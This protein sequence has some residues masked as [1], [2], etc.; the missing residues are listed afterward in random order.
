MFFEV[1]KS[2]AVTSLAG[3]VLAGLITLAKPF[4]RK[5]FGYAWHYYIWLAV[6]LV[7][8]LP[9]RF[10]VWQG[11]AC[12]APVLY[13]QGPE[14]SQTAVAMP[15]PSASPVRQNAV[16]A[17]LERMKQAVGNEAQVYLLFLW[18]V[19]AVGFFL[20]YL[21]GYFL[22]LR[23]IHRHSVQIQCPTLRQYTDKNVRV[24]LC[25]ESSMP[26]MTGVFRPV[27]ILPN[28]PL[29]PVQMDHILRHEMTHF[30]RRDLLY[31]WFAVLV[32]CIH[33]FN[34]VVYYVMRQ[35][36]IECEISCDLSVVARMSKDEEKRYIGTILSLLSGQNAKA[37]SLTTGMAGSKKIL[38]RRFV[39]MKHKKTTS[40]RVSVISA[41]VAAVM[42]T[43]TVFASGVLSGVWTRDDAIDPTNGGR[44]LDPENKP[45]V[46]NI[47]IDFDA[48]GPQ[49]IHDIADA[50][51]LVGESAYSVA[52]K[53]DLIEL[54]NMLSQAKKFK[55]SGC[56]FNAVLTITRT[57][58]KTGALL[59]ASDS[60][61]V[62]QS[63]GMYYDYSDGDNSRLLSMF[64]IDGDTLFH[65]QNIHNN[66]LNSDR[67]AE[68]ITAV[69]GIS[70]ERIA[71]AVEDCM[72]KRAAE[73][74]VPSYTYQVASYTL[75]AGNKD[76]E[77]SV[78]I[79]PEQGDSYDYLT[80]FFEKLGE[81]WVIS[82]FLIEK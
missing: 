33:W 21:L 45:S 37:L 66:V 63:D 11:E 56:P 44:G 42:L 48:F 35:I 23:N 55:G 27:L 76:V 67:A 38:K 40:K 61:A 28:R 12:P 32:K 71:E 18:L 4:T 80:I 65:A 70:P 47:L 53:N 16:S 50:R 31:K 68:G 59:L 5:L 69:P 20:M 43:T 58:G 6:L 49:D 39:M 78:E 62:Y 81:E 22:L 41:V 79:R 2:L 29:S 72:R 75:N 19:G 46:E 25:D 52:E 51:L 10:S 9:L 34:P 26:F 54:E 7:M 60:C 24:R 82:N 1:L 13:G 14:V 17:G 73:Y 36:N 64:G 74:D 8:L 3:S 15:E 77:V 30:H 57:D